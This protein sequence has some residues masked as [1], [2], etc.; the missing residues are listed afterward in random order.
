MKTIIILILL[1]LCSTAEAHLGGPH[2]HVRQH[3]RV[4]DASHDEI[5]AQQAAILEQLA[6]IR[7]L[8][9]GIRI[10]F[11]GTCS[12]GCT[13]NATGFLLLR[14][15]YTAGTPITKDHVVSFSYNS[16]SGGC[17]GLNNCVFNRAL[18]DASGVVTLL[19]EEQ[20]FA[21]R[22]EIDF[23]GQQT[24]FNSFEDGSWRFEDFDTGVD[25][26][27]F[28]HIWIRRAPFHVR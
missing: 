16:T 12:L 14:P 6:G 21:L 7:A 9:P 27:G 5:L 26:S 4:A 15:E 25:D 8:L 1:V 23:E 24:G 10:E 13:G 2:P 11:I 28:T 17:Y 20:G 22:I 19:P 3:H 18:L